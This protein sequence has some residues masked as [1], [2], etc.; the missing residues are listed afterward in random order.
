MDTM[1]PL[2]STVVLGRCIWNCN[3]YVCVCVSTVCLISHI[4]PET[5]TKKK[6]KCACELLKRE[7]KHMDRAYN[8][9]VEGGAKTKV[10]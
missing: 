5:E 1:N 10:L 7:T 6:L 4:N 8:V 2:C 3:V 9:C